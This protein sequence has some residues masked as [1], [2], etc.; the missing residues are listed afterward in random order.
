MVG[1]SLK[2]QGDFRVLGQNTLFYE[3][4]VILESERR[5]YFR[6]SSSTG[7]ATS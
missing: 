2:I 6:K 3:M 7:R 4:R 5:L 1:L